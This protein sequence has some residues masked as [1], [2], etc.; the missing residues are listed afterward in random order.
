MKKFEYKYIGF[1]KGSNVDDDKEIE[2]NLNEL[3]KQGFEIISALEVYNGKS[4]KLV[5]KKEI[6]YE[7]NKQ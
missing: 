4:M 6:Q 3:G 1:L 7:D 2:N 5:F